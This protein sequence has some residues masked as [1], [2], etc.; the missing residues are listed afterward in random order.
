MTRHEKTAAESVEMSNW[1]WEVELPPT[2]GRLVSQR[3]R[4]LELF[5][6]FQ[7]FHHLLPIIHQLFHN[8]SWTGHLDEGRIFVF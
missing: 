6:S 3:G 4:R 8:G 5:G 7:L 2:A 1:Q